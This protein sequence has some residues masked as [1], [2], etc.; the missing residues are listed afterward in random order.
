MKCCFGI[1]LFWII[2]QGEII[3]VLHLLGAFGEDKIFREVMKETMIVSSLVKLFLIEDDIMPLKE[4]RALTGLLLV[5]LKI[6]ETDNTNTDNYE[7]N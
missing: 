1:F 2:F 5:L 7:D 3:R 6:G 4:K